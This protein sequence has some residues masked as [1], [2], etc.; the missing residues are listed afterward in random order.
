MRRWRRV[1]VTVLGGCLAALVGAAGARAAGPMPTVPQFLVAAADAVGMVREATAVALAPDGTLYLV[2]R[3][4]D[5]VQHV[6]REGTVLDLWGDHGLAPGQFLGPEDIAV[7]ADG[8]VFV[9]DAGNHRVQRF[10][11][12]GHYLRSYGLDDGW[13]G[14]L[15]GPQGVAVAGDGTV[16]VTEFATGSVKHFRSDGTFLGAFGQEGPL[17]ER[18]DDPRQIR[19]APD[20]SLYVNDFGHDRIQRFSPTGIRRGSLSVAVGRHRPPGPAALAVGPDGT[21]YIAHDYT[22]IYPVSPAGVKGEAI[23]VYQAGDVQPSALAAGADGALYVGVV[24]S[25][26]RHQ[27]PTM[28]GL[29][30]KSESPWLEVDLAAAQAGQPAPIRRSLAAWALGDAPAQ[31][32]D[33]RGAAGVASFVPGVAPDGTI[34]VADGAN[35]RVQRFRP[36]GLYLGAWGD[37]GDSADRLGLA[38]AAD[39][40]V[41]LSGAAPGRLSQRAPDGH[42]L[43]GVPVDMHAQGATGYTNQVDGLAVAPDGSLVIA[44]TDAM[45]VQRVSSA[46]GAMLAAWGQ[47]SLGSLPR[48]FGG[49]SGN[50]ALPTCNHQPVAV[51]PDGRTVY[52]LDG[53]EGQVE[54]FDPDSRHVGQWG[55][56]TAQSD[57]ATTARGIAVAP[58]ATVYVADT[59]SHRVLRFGPDGQLLG[60]LPGRGRDPA[61]AEEPF[62]LALAG[63]GRLVVTDRGN[64]RLQVFGTELPTAW[65]GELFGNRWLTE[66]PLA[67]VHPPRV[68]FDWGL[69]APDAA[70]PPDGFSARFERRLVLGTGPHTF[71]VTAT[72]GVR[73]WAGEKLLVDAW[74]ELG[75]R[76]A[77]AVDVEDG[78]PVPIRLDYNDPGGKAAVSLAID[79]PAVV[80]PPTPTAVARPP[81]PAPDRPPA[82]F[83]PWTGRPR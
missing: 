32:G 76:R 4:A 83:L 17:E 56:L 75:V 50:V 61:G 11:G 78:E 81:A 60:I 24:P 7:G 28:P 38:V 27:R 8:D 14:E 39:G 65:R 15:L 6:D 79:D 20:G 66:R 25:G 48:Y 37:L 55:G 67:I 74:N 44:R 40:S 34:Y 46:T 72:G 80:V 47:P 53:A 52:T 30:T 41:W 13:D 77:V 36:D 45:T 68:D 19:L 69:A 43:G 22:R 31:F 42:D 16:F 9:V 64:D 2:D 12:R 59:A 33:H 1:G 70:L 51:A 21:V 54:L 10:D 26:L 71:A 3:L 82:V 5:R 62:G 29:V 23:D 58:D 63:D 49:C 57:I 35:R 73:L 18:L